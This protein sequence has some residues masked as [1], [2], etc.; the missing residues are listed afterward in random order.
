MTFSITQALIVFIL[1]FENLVN[2]FPKTAEYIEV[3]VNTGREILFPF[4]QTVVLL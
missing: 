2:K 1:F 3:A 4:R